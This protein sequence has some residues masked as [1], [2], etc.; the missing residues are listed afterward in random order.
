MIDYSKGKIYKI[1]CDATDDIYIYIYIQVQQ[2][3]RYINDYVLIKDKFP[4]MTLNLN[5]CLQKAIAK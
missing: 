3:R 4:D 5:Y 1:V 2:L